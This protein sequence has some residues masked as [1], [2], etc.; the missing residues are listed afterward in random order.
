M[1]WAILIG[2]LL[3][4][5]A[6]PALASTTDD[7]DENGKNLDPSRGDP[8]ELVPAITE[9][10]DDVPDDTEEVDA[11]ELEAIGRVLASECASHTDEEREAI[12]WH[13]RTY[14]AHR[15]STVY[16]TSRARGDWSEQLGNR[17]PW[18]TSKPA[19]ARDTDQA[20][21]VLVQPMSAAPAYASSFFEPAQQ[22]LCSRNAE[23]YRAGGG[24]GADTTPQGSAPQYFR[25]RH[26]HL[27]ADGVRAK[28]GGVLVRTVGRWEFYR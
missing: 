11:N 24:S 21:A 22:D 10:V 12:A 8:P 16:D 3:L 28:W 17:P 27:N 4:F 25:F 7:L 13:V 9:E 23:R 1:K 2:L 6:G 5:L 19:R 15:K 20:Q 18:S 26:Y 14:A